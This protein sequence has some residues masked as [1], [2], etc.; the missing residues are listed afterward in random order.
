MRGSA[1]RSLLLSSG[2]YHRTDDIS[3]S[4]GFKSPSD[5][6]IP[7]IRLFPGMPGRYPGT[8]FCQRQAI[9][10]PSLLFLPGQGFAAGLACFYGDGLSSL[11]DAC[12]HGCGGRVP[13]EDDLVLAQ[14]ADR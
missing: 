6:V 14:V 8:G 10:V 2:E 4:R 9:G 12:L 13:G 3:P 11:G 5:T 7:Y 1:A